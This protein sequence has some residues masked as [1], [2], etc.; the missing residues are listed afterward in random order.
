MIYSAIHPASLKT[1]IGRR[2]DV[3]H[4]TWQKHSN[5]AGTGQI[6]VYANRYGVPCKGNGKTQQSEATAAKGALKHT[7]KHAL[8]DT[9]THKHIHL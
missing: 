2:I 8:T 3:L 7:R 6:R 9:H 1:G 5:G 4:M